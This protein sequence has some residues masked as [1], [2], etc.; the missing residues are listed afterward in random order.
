MDRQQMLDRI[1]EL[2]VMINSE[3]AGQR[4]PEFGGADVQF[5]TSL[6]IAT[7]LV[8]AWYLYGG[9]LTFLPG[10]RPLHNQFGEYGFY[11]AIAMGILVLLQL[12]RKF[13][14]GKPKADPEYAA[15]AERV[16]QFQDER[17]LLQEKLKSL[18]E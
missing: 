9:E 5:P 16:R 10:A 2:T 8:Y 4:A 15:S 7:G 3:M 17:R 13:I 12:A 14:K 11:V 18:A 1:A 6:I